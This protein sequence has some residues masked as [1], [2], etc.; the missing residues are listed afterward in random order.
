MDA[1]STGA[2]TSNGGSFV[3][4]NGPLHDAV[5]RGAR[6]ASRRMASNVTVGI[7]IGTSSVKAVAADDDGNVVARSRIPHEFYVPSPQR[8]EHDAARRVARRSAARARRA[9]RRRPARGVGRGDG[10]VVDRGRRRR[11]AV[12]ARPALRRRARPPDTTSDRDRRARASSCSSCAGRRSERPDARGYWM[13]QAVANHALDGR[14]DHLDDRSRRPRARS[15]TGRRGTTQLLAECG[16]RAEQMPEI[17]SPGQALAEVTRPRR[18]ACSKAARSTRSGEQLVAGADDAGDVLV[19]LG[20]TLIVWAVVAGAGRGSRLLHDPAHRAGQ[21][22][23][24]WAEQRGR[25]VPQLGRPHARRRRRAGRSRTR[26]PVWV[27]YPRG[28]RVPFQDPDAARRSSSTSTSRTTRPRFAG[29]RSKRRRSSTR[30]MIEATPGPGAAASSRPAAARASTDGSTAL[31][32]C[33]G[34]PVHV[35]AV[36]EG[37]ALGAA[38]LARLAAG[39]E[40][41]MQ[42]RAPAGRARRTRRRSGSG[43]VGGG[44]RAV[45]AVLRSRGLSFAD[46]SAHDDP[47]RIGASSWPWQ[48]P[49]ALRRAAAAPGVSTSTTTGIAVVARPGRAADDEIVL[50]ERGLPTQAIATCD[51]ATKL[52]VQAGRVDG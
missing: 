5:H 15:S 20:T 6:V 49:W 23:R 21:V 24:R 7:D 29:P 30:R 18:T 26:V 4:T 36:P 42:R 47:D 33:T 37:G 51:D 40:T 11:R 19:I 27:P 3:C 41:S 34:L 13:A 38:F 45:R 52:F 35:C 25:A 32:D 1:R 31:A 9:R 17:G 10:A 43:M 46:R 39:L 28:E 2:P 16:A 48:S 22:P 14:A 44:R 50:V 8:F 12:H